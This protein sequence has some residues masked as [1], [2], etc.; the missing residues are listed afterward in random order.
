VLLNR[1]TSSVETYNDIDGDVVN[2]FRILRDRPDEI[3]RAISLTLFSREEYHQ[4]IYGS[5]KG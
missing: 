2:F 5:I 3:T 4:A 1:A